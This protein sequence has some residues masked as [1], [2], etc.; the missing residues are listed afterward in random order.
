MM[1]LRTIGQLAK[2]L[3]VDQHQALYVIRTRDIQPVARAGAYRL[4]DS[5]AVKRIASELK[6]IASER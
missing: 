1:N 2:E 6:Q 5:A 4:F 3:K